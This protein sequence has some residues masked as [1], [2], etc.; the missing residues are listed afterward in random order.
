M[1]LVERESPRGVVTVPATSNARARRGD[2]L[3]VSARRPLASWQVK[4]ART[5]GARTGAR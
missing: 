4:F 5:P 2:Y 3:A 1:E